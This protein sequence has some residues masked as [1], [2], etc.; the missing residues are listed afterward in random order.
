MCIAGLCSDEERVDRTTLRRTGRPA[1]IWSVQC[2]DETG[3]HVVTF[4]I[5]SEIA[6]KRG[7]QSDELTTPR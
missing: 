3:T 2:S 7:I 4:S 6:S 5:S 1:L